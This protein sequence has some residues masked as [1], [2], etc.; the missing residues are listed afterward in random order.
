MLNLYLERIKSGKDLTEVEAQSALSHIMEGKATEQEIEDLLINLS[1]KGESIEEI[2]GFARAM[3]Q[4]S[5]KVDLGTT[6]LLDTCGTGGDGGKIFNVSTAVAIIAAAAGVAVAKHGNRAISGKSGSI[7]VLEQLGIAIDL[8]VAELKTIFMQTNLAFLFALHHHPA[9]KYVGPVRK[10]LK[11]RT[12]FNM[13]GP[14]TNPAGANYQLIGVYSEELTDKIATALL[15]LGCRKGLIVHSYSGLD[16]LSIDGPTK[17]TEI[18][19]G[20]LSSFNIEPTQVGLQQSLLHEISGGTPEEN[21]NIIRKILEGE[22]GPNRDIVLFNA[23]AALYTSNHSTSIEAGV[24]L[25]A[26]IIDEGIA[27]TKLNQYIQISNEL[28]MN[29]GAQH[30]I[31]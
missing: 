17:V 12:I 5:I 20:N 31:R 25:A 2:I 26:R 11:K 8:D 15:K 28:V 9:M 19:N 30:D 21:A 22:K 23:G 7:D 6:E 18:N 4:Y 24:E 3:R 29:R 1:S 27:W 13:L 14:I 16:E 10:K